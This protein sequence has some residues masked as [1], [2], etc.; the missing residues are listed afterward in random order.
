MA[1]YSY[2]LALPSTPAFTESSWKLKRAVDINQSPFSGHTSTYEYD[3][4]LWTAVLSLPPM[5]RDQAA[6]WQSFFMKLHGR[7]GTF[8]LGDPD[9]KTIRGAGPTSGNVALSSAAAVGD[10]SLSVSITAADG[11]VAFKE[12]DYIQLGT[13]AD[14]KLHMIVNDV[15]VTSNAATIDI[16]PY[17]KLAVANLSIL[18]YTAPKGVFFMDANELGWDA[19]HVSKYGITFSCTEFL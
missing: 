7:R 3:M 8:L 16:E 14:A 18:E 15:V 9:A 6:Q 13:G 17:V 5:K 10:D 19:D 1:T 4:A 11:T 12:G 2:P